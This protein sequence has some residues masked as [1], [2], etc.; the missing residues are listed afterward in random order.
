MN[1]RFDVS[2]RADVADTVD[3]RHRGGFGRVEADRWV[4]Y[5][6]PL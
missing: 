6:A 2:T 3:V 4:D 5:A 1:E